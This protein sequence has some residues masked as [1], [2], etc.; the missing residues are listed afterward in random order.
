MPRRRDAIRAATVARRARGGC[1]GSLS[2]PWPRGKNGIGGT[3]TMSVVASRAGHSLAATGEMGL[4]AEGGPTNM[5]RTANAR[6]AGVA[7]LV[8]I[9][10]GIADMVLFGRAT[11]GAGIA[12]KLASIAQHSSDAR[13]SVLL[14]LLCC[15][16]ALVL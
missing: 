2:P 9:A 11:S 16:C 14:D 12:A 6:V 3:T 7:F 13:I 8:Y 1:E 10:A 5:T 15:F 4:A